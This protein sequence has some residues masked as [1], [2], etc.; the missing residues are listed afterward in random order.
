MKR[1]AKAKLKKHI[2]ENARDIIIVMLINLD[3]FPVYAWLSFSTRDIILTQRGDI[4][5]HRRFK[6]PFHGR[7]LDIAIKELIGTWRRL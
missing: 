7:E 4:I 5:Y 1:Q 2:L 3:E 6:K